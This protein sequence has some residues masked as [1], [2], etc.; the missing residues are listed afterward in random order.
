[1]ERKPKHGT[2][3]KYLGN[4]FTN[5]TKTESEKNENMKKRPKQP[6]C[7]SKAHTKN[8]LNNK[9]KDTGSGMLFCSDFSTR[10]L[11][12]VQGH[13]MRLARGGRGARAARFSSTESVTFRTLPQ[14]CYTQRSHYRTEPQSLPQLEKYTTMNSIHPIRTRRCHSLFHLPQCTVL[15]ITIHE[16]PLPPSSHHHHRG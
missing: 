8:H 13:L 15:M 12:Q 1:M 11:S 7:H 2:A 16:Q 4:W 5:D 6:H 14:K 9:N 10:P 3:F